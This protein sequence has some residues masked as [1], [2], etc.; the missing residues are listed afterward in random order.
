MEVICIDNEGVETGLTLYKKYEIEESFTQDKIDLLKG[1]LVTNDIGSMGFY[2]TNRFI[3]IEEWRDK[4][5]NK[6][7]PE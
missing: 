3:S 4:Q 5:L 1:F 6:V 7:I 2:A